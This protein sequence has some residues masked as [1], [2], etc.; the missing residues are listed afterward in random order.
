MK[1]LTKEEI[2]AAP[3]LATELVE[4]PEWGEGAG[5]R[6]RAFSLAV[7]DQYLEP[8]AGLDPDEIKAAGNVMSAARLVVFSVV[9][10]AGNRVF[11]VED[12]PRLESKSIPAI[13]RIAMAAKRLNGLGVSEVQAAAKNSE[14]SPT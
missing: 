10:E 7:R 8:I 3:D 14:A 12:I 11:D 1:L 4:V 9:D 6:V 2:F 5:V 13:N